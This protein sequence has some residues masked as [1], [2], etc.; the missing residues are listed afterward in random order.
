M[1]EIFYFP[2]SWR[3]RAGNPLPDYESSFREVHAKGKTKIGNRKGGFVSSGFQVQASGFAC[4]GIMMRGVSVFRSMPVL[5]YAR[6][7]QTRHAEAFDR[8]LPG[9]EFFHSQGI[10]PA[11]VFEAEK[12]SSDGR[13][14]FGLA[15]DDP[16]LRIGRRQISKRERAAIR[17]DHI[18]HAGPSLFFAHIFYTPPSLPG[19]EDTR[20]ILRNR[21]MPR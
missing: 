12:P 19:P 5:L 14:H 7:A 15:A 2:V 16:A 17:A 6:G 4:N 9:E 20:R 8:A 21:K 11:R 3:W 10:T 1:P 18:A 13:N